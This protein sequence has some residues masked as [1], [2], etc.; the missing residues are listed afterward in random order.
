LRQDFRGRQKKFSLIGIKRYFIRH[1]GKQ[2]DDGNDVESIGRRHSRVP[3]TL[4]LAVALHGSHDMTLL[5]VRLQ[6]NRRLIAIVL[7]LAGFGSALIIYFAAKPAPAN[8]LGYDPEDSKQYLREIELYGGKAN[9]LVSEFRQWF[10]SLWHGRR[11]AFT[12]VCLT[13]ATVLFFWVASTPL[14]PEAGL[15]SHQ[16]SQLPDGTER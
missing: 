5:P 4:V 3:P 15:S 14:P 6:P 8:P 2:R 10:D 12:V 13:L 9:V 11:L 16:R 7:L 1:P